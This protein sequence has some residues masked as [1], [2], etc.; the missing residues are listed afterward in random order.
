MVFH[1]MQSLPAGV[2]ILGPDECL[3][4]DWGWWD[5]LLCA[6]YRCLVAQACCMS[7]ENNVSCSEPYAAASAVH[8]DAHGDWQAC[9][10]SLA[11]RFGT[12]RV[13]CSLVQ[14]AC[15][16]HVM[17]SAGMLVKMS[18]TFAFNDFCTI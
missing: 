11:G 13:C 1:P 15:D 4:G 3:M 17:W 14:A 9:C 5:A 10:C 12:T 7:A 16:R 8:R 18:H 2:G 6:A